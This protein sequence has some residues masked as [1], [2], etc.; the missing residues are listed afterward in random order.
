MSLQLCLKKFRTFG[1]IQGNIVKKLIPTQFCLR[2]INYPISKERKCCTRWRSI[3]T[4]LSGF[5][6]KRLAESAGKRSST[7]LTLRLFM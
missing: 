2:L 7:G 3:E 4:Q 6:S 1:P 5:D